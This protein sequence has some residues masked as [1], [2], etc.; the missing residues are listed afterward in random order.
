M[1]YPFRQKITYVESFTSNIYYFNKDVH[2]N[3]SWKQCD[4]IYKNNLYIKFNFAT[5]FF[6]TFEHSTSVEGGCRDVRGCLAKG[7]WLE[8]WSYRTEVIHHSTASIRG[9]SLQSLREMWEIKG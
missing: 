1:F 7:G 9:Y 4:K 2:A 5:C 6:L 3:I 8:N